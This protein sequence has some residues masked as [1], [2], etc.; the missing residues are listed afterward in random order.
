M[1]L[2]DEPEIRTSNISSFEE[3]RE[4]FPIEEYR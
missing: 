4:R 1:E 2:A 3:M